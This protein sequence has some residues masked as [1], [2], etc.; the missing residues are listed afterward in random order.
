MYVEEGPRSLPPPPPS[1]LYLSR[2]CRGYF[3]F[4]GAGTRSWKL[5]TRSLTICMYVHVAQG[6]TRSGGKEERIET[7]KDKIL[8]SNTNPCIGIHRPHSNNACVCT[9][10]RQVWIGRSFYQR[11][12]R[13]CTR[14]MR[15]R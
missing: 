6:S 12:R 4:C 9:T 15:S 7:A 1:S 11:T 8:T 5:S 14:C 3:L 10:H 13:T 2:L